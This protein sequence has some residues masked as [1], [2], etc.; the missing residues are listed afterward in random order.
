MAPDYFFT[1][2]ARTHEQS[3]FYYTVYI[4]VFSP[5]ERQTSGH[6]AFGH[7]AATILRIAG[8][9]RARARVRPSSEEARIKRLL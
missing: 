9:V 7:W 1:Q 6:M 5:V 8:D 4:P 3:I 2:V